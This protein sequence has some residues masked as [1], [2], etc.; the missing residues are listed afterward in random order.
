MRNSRAYSLFRIVGS[1]QTIQ[2]ESNASQAK[3]THHRKT[4]DLH[5]RRRWRTKEVV[6]VED[7]QKHH[8]AYHAEACESRSILRSRGPLPV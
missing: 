3:V 1:P 2:P 6:D 7:E 8:N 4:K 5:K